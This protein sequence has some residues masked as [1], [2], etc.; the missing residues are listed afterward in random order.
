MCGTTF[1]LDKVQIYANSSVSE[2]FT[3][4]AWLTFMQTKYNEEEKKKTLTFNYLTWRGKQ[5]Y[6]V[7]AGSY[8]TAETASYPHVL[9]PF[10][11]TDFA[12]ISF[13]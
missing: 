5:K 1:V 10:Y 11:L 13:T 6:S 9:S 2:L 12:I 7:D 3:H 4:L 8:K